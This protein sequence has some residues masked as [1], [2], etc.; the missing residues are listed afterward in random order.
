MAASASPADTSKGVEEGQFPLSIHLCSK[1]MTKS[2]SHPTLSLELS[3]SSKT[4]PGRT[5]DPAG[6]QRPGVR[7]GP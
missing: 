1:D 3:S 2:S 5:T 4:A 6:C 7:I